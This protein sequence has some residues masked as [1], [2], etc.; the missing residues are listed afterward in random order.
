MQKDEGVN[1]IPMTSE[2]R[3]LQVTFA[4]SV[5]EGVMAGAIDDELGYKVAASFKALFMCITRLML[6]PEIDPMLIEAGSLIITEATVDAFSVA[7]EEICKNKVLFDN[8]QVLA[9][10]IRGE[11][12]DDNRSFIIAD[13]SPKGLVG[14]IRQAI[15]VVLAER[16]GKYFTTTDVFKLVCEKLG[17]FVSRDV[18]YNHVLPM[19]MA[20]EIVGERDGENGRWR[21]ACKK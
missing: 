9:N 20:G 6:D 11:M 13:A 15:L 17:Y 8:R 5:I 7:V 3:G 21:W 19:Q 2:L 10:A 16:P 1:T 18:V 14:D 4:E 12:I